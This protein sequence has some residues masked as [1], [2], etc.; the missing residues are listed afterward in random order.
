MTCVLTNEA[1]ED[2]E[3]RRIPGPDQAI[4]KTWGCGGRAGG[5]NGRVRP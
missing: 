1:V 3:E 4:E 5:A 2:V